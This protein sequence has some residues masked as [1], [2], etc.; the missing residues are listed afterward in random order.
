[1][2]RFGLLLH[3]LCS[4]ALQPVRLVPESYRRCPLGH[5][6]RPSYSSIP[7]PFIGPSRNLSTRKRLRGYY[8]QGFYY[9]AYR[10]SAAEHGGNPSR[11]HQSILRKGETQQIKFRSTNS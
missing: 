1:M 7:R 11:L 2:K 5:D 10:Y 4:P 6:H 3:W 8:E 9:S